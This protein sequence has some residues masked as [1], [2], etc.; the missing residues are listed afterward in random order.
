MTARLA[1]GPNRLSRV[2]RGSLTL[3]A[4][5][6]KLAAMTGRAARLAAI[7]RT[8]QLGSASWR[9]RGVLRPQTQPPGSSGALSAGRRSQRVRRS[10]LD[11]QLGPGAGRDEGRRDPAAPL[12]QPGRRGGELAR[13]RPRPRQVLAHSRRPRPGGERAVPAGRLPCLERPA[14]LAAGG[15]LARLSRG[16]RRLGRGGRERRPRPC[17]RRREGRGAG[18][19]P[20]REAAGARSRG[21]G[22]R[23]DHR[24]YRHRSRSPESR[25][26]RRRGGPGPPG[27]RAALPRVRRPQ[28]EKG[29]PP[30]PLA[31]R[32]RRGREGPGDQLVA[33]RERPGLR[34][35][36]PLQP[37]LPRH[38]RHDPLAVRAPG[39]PA[40]AGASAG[41]L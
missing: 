21:R 24:A 8:L 40:P 34:R 23:P 2:R 41:P 3:P 22:H 28:P 13:L 26:S 20:A 10:L 32:R 15:H 29:H 5:S 16:A 4:P 12:R 31:G 25:G 39:K 11:R 1:C 9:T 19:V 33:P 35:S 30:V 27:H 14:G 38:P 37:R 17:G 6:G 7:L 18:A 36:G